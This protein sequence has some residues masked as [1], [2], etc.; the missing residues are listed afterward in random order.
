LKKHALRILQNLDL[1]IA[2]IALT[3]LIFITFFGV[4]MRYFVAKPF[5][6]QEELQ[7]ICFVWITFM[8]AGAAFRT[9]SHVAIDI[10]VDLF[11]KKIQKIVDVLIYLTVVLVLLYLIVQSGVYI[12]QLHDSNRITSILHIPYP[13]IY[14]AVPVGCVLMIINCGIQSWKFLKQPVQER[15]EEEAK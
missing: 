15:E 8:A 11:P 10:V 7:I 6:W 2:G 14:S 1:I 9:G 12:V 4:I 5:V 13:L 3:V